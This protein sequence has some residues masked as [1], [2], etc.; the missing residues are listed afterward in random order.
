M[1]DEASLTGRLLVATPSLLDPNFLRTVILL[2][3]HSD[4]GAVGVVLNRPSDISVAGEL[5]AWQP[6]A[7]EPAVM[8]VGGP[9]EQAAILGLAL[10]RSDETVAGVRPVTGRLGVLDLNRQPDPRAVERIRL[11]AGY[12]GWAAGQLEAEIAT[13]S[14]FVIDAEPTDV[15]TEDPRALWRTV[16]V[17]QGGVFRT[18]PD[19][20]TLN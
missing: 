9:V 10:T 6:L 18:I 17:R 5:A 16:L 2:L 11:F 14:W 13:G 4:D 20:P 19:D 1:S 3:D 7:A 12:A 15:F 8:F